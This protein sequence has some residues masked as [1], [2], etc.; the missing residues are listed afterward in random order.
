[1]FTLLLLLKV[2]SSPSS[3]SLSSLYDHISLIIAPTFGVFL[4]RIDLILM[5]ILAVTLCSW[6]SF[7]PFR[8]RG[9][10]FNCTTAETDT[11][12]KI[13]FNSALWKNKLFQY[14]ETL[15]DFSNRCGLLCWCLLAVGYW[16]QICTNLCKIL[17]RWGAISS[18]ATVVLNKW[19]SN[20][21][22]SLI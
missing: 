12:T 17:R 13:P 2:S 16:H 21:A 1:M 8:Q 18:L 7:Y 3:W 9:S 10:L 4:L 5:T 15:L 14:Q 19:R 20:L 22:L 11:K 6:Q